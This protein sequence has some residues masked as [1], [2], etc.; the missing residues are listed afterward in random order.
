[1]SS[2]GRSVSAGWAG[3]AAAGAAAGARRAGAFFRLDALRDVDLAFFAVR[4]GFAR[5]DPVFFI[6]LVFFADLDFAFDRPLV[7][8]LVRRFLAM[9][10]SR[11]NAAVF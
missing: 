2:I 8:E 4:A 5:R 7:F 6:D 1:M 9:R 11:L 10:A 3:A